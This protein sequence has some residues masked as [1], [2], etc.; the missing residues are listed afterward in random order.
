MLGIEINSDQ[1]LATLSGESIA[2]RVWN[3]GEG[4]FLMGD[5]SGDFSCTPDMTEVFSTLG[6]IP[7]SITL[8]RKEVSLQ[9]NSC[10]IS[11]QTLTTKWV[12]TADEYTMEYP[13]ADYI[14]DSFFLNMTDW[15]YVE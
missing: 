1:Y 6:N 12:L 3:E 7:G 8:P 14:A 2:I 9:T 11:E 10:S 15:Q 5:F 13:T 4:D